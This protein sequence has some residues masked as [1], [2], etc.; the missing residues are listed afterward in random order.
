MD[1]A[2]T[3]IDFQDG[4]LYSRCGNVKEEKRTLKQMAGFYGDQLA[5]ARMEPDRVVYHMQISTDEQEGMAG[6]LLFGTSFVMPGRVGA[7]YFMTKGHFH[8]HLDCAEYYWC[9]AG[10]GA[11]ILM[12]EKGICRTEKMTRGSLHYIPGRVAHRLANTGNEVLAVGACWPSDAGHDY[13]TIAQMGF[14]ARLLAGPDG[15]ELVNVWET[16]QRLF[17]AQEIQISG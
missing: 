4:C 3:W 8:S 14:S 9:I 6:G 17:A 7:E 5:Y 15:P 12:D 11:L 2:K 10:E 13:E 16:Q 1:S